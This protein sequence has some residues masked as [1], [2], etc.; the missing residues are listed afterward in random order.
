MSM[1]KHSEPTTVD[2]PEEPTSRGD[3]P[4]CICSAEDGQSRQPAI[5]NWGAF[6]KTCGGR[7]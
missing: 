5:Y 6:C 1:S 2:V 7:C 3:I 4:E